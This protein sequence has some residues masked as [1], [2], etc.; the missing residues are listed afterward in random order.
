MKKIAIIGSGVAGLLA[1]HGLLKAGMAVT[2]YSDRTAEQWLTE[3]RPTGTAARFDLA[4]V[5]TTGGKP[6]FDGVPFTPVKFNLTGTEGEAFWVPYYHKN[7]GPSWNLGF[8]AK[9]GSKMDRFDAAKS[10]GDVLAIGKQVI[11]ELFPWDYV[12]AKNMQ[13]ADPNGWLVGGFAPTVRQTL[14]RLPSGRR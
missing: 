9:P 10:G 14:G 6:G 4:M 1:A 11:K 3:S 12:W 13:L 5:I 8:E 7:A 2:L